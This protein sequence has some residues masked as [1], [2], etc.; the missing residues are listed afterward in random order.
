MRRWKS[1]ICDRCQCEYTPTSSKQRFCPP[2]GAIN[3]ASYT[4]GVRDAYVSKLPH[5]HCK[6]GHEFTPENT[7]IQSKTGRRYCRV[8]V[9]IRVGDWAKE[10]HSA[11]FA[12]GAFRTRVEEQENRCAICGVGFSGKV[13]PFADH[14]HIE[15]P[16]PRGALCR[17]C[18]AGI[19]MLQDSPE[20]LEAAA[21][22]I[23]HYRGSNAAFVCDIHCP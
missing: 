18:N 17:L 20:I 8:C 15:P 11:G 6:E 14:E 22:Y 7:Y 16:K 2:C 23:R 19:G 5:T 9:L 1:R 13:K 10:K 12:L 21:R 3:K 4:R